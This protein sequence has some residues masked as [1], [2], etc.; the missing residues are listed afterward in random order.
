MEHES[1]A[2]FYINT[3]PDLTVLLFFFTHAQIVKSPEFLLSSLNHFLEWGTLDLLQAFIM[4]F[5]SCNC[6]DSFKISPASLQ[7]M[8][9][10]EPML[11]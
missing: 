8:G 2:I 3:W 10:D 1:L 6:G 7:I 4:D 9:G 11:F 5:L